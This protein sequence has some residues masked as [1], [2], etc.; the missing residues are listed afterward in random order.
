MPPEAD[1]YFAISPRS[2][3]RPTRVEFT[4][5]GREF[6]LTADAGVFSSGRLDP[7]TEVLL[8]K[9]VPPAPET[10]GAL[11]DLGCGYGPI[12]CFLASAAP[13]AVVYAVDVNSRALDLARANAE[14]LGVADRVV[15]VAPD[16]VPDG[17][18][19]RQIWSNPPIR[20]GKAQLHT[21]LRRWLPRLIPDGMAWLVVARNL[22]ADS[23]QTWLTEQGW[24]VARH[25]S[26]RGFRVLRVSGTTGRNSGDEQPRDPENA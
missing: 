1:H 23:L 13:R 19:F 15:A 17:L 16:G 4:A 25:A 24:T 18:Q 3:N 9:V 8:H 2:A 10:S 22:G 26:Q 21:L 11:L 7:G 14:A 20:I 12:A 6:H 5:A